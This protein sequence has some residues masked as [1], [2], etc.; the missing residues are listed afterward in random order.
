[1]KAVRKVLLGIVA[2]A[3]IAT[4]SI[5]AYQAYQRFVLSH[6]N[7]RTDIDLSVLKESMESNNELSTEKYLYTDSVSVTDQNTLGII[8]RDD[9]VLP[10]TDAT[11]V[12]QFDG[13]IKAGYDLNDA[14]VY[15]EG[16]D[17][18]VVELPAAKV[19]SHETGDVEVIYEQENIMNPLHAG[20]ESSW[21]DGQKSA[22]E[23]RAESL[24]LY[25]DANE[26]AKATFESMFS[27]ALPEG[28]NL[29]VRF[30]DDA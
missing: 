17:T 24:G 14:N 13:V 23:A 9:I 30:S 28:V 3:L 4:A 12:L 29:D 2:I 7:G 26:N 10:F 20:Q 6:P 25:D 5:L 21:I 8:G 15:L 27:S 19:L 16:D 18:V 1:V 22:M 11:Y